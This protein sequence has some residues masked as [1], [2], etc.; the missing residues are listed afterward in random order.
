MV[1]GLEAAIYF[2]FERL[3]RI[4]LIAVLLSSQVDSYVDCVSRH[5]FDRFVENAG[6]TVLLPILRQQVLF[7]RMYNR[8]CSYEVAFMEGAMGRGVLGHDTKTSYTPAS[9]PLQR[10]H[11]LAGSERLY[12]FALNCHAELTIFLHNEIS[13]VKELALFPPNGDIRDLLEALKFHH[14]LVD[15]Q[16]SSARQGSMPR[17]QALLA[18]VSNSSSLQCSINKSELIK[19]AGRFNDQS[20]RR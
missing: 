17:A 18:A 8:P 10:L 19:S 14:N 4:R 9:M 7:L 3:P 6:F 16:V 2:R 11:F 1:C 5:C 12:T 15:L 20:I 13:T